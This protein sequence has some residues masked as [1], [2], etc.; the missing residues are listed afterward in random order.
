MRARGGDHCPLTQ[1]AGD[2]AARAIRGEGEP[3]RHPC[4]HSSDCTNPRRRGLERKSSTN[5]RSVTRCCRDDRRHETRYSAL[6]MSSSQAGGGSGRRP[7]AR[8][9]ATMQMSGEQW[10]QR[11]REA[12]ANRHGM[13][14]EGEA[15]HMWK[16]RRKP[17][18]GPEPWPSGE[19][20]NR[21]VAVPPVAQ[22]PWRCR[23]AE[24]CER[25]CMLP[26]M[27]GAIP[28]SP[29]VATEARIAYPARL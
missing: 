13:Q 28:I 9:Q 12:P 27:G 29:A 26:T 4:R 10:T 5:D 6:S 23:R 11:R 25:S 2:E 20:G 8:A 18:L 14:G 24:E 3:A 21:N 19:Q 1:R 16:H 15:G 17:H 22:G 7:T